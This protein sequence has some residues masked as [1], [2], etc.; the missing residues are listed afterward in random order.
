MDH[1]QDPIFEFWVSQVLTRPS[2][3]RYN[4][5]V[6]ILKQIPRDIRLIVFDLDG[7]LID[8]KEDLALSVNLMRGE[9]GL[10]PLE[11]ELIASYVGQ[12]VGVLV[13]RALGSGKPEAVTDADVERG[14]E[15]FLRTYRLH[16]LDHTVTYDGVREA[17]GELD[18]RQSPASP[19]SVLPG[20]LTVPR[21]LAVLTNKPVIFS[22]AI[23]AGLGIA[24]H[25][26]FVY[27]GNSPELNQTKKPDPVGVF[28][29]MGDTGAAAEQTL[30]VGD[31][32]TDVL[33]GRNAGVWTCGVTY[34]I[35]SH[36]LEATPPDVLLGDLREL[37]PLLGL[38]VQ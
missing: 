2:L 37:P 8:S 1:G 26:A 32:D 36:T 16:M 29:L 4:G 11:Y 38:G 6:V 15:I 10:A 12:G 34:G 13:R 9:M 23:L 18:D 5:K 21:K 20:E 27:G 25:F 24:S 7:T 19:R 31:S 35:G 17:L 28:K 3:A 30:I 22:R 33:T 14:V